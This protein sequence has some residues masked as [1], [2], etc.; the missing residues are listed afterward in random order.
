MELSYGLC[1]LFNLLPYTAAG[2]GLFAR[3]PCRP[4]SGP[5]NGCEVCRGN[6][7]RKPSFDSE[8]Q[9]ANELSPTLDHDRV[10]RD[11]YPQGRRSWLAGAGR[12]GRQG[13]DP[14]VY[15]RYLLVQPCGCLGR[16]RALFWGLSTEETQ[17][18]ASGGGIAV[19]AEPSWTS[20]HCQGVPS[21]PD[22]G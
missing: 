9:R 13:L 5:A 12:E 8:G 18:R 20:R 14:S 10:A 2:R 4:P 1:R 6:G 15:E 22:R 19:G 16:C 3:L 17:G 7:M 21:D 11:G